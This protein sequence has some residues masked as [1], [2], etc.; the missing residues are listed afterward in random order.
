MDRLLDPVAQASWLD[1]PRARAY[2]LI[3]LV[4]A[5]GSLLFWIAGSR[6]GIDR[7]GH[8]L[9]TDFLAFWSAAR[10]AIAG[11][12]ADAWTLARIHAVERAAV[13]V[14]P[15]PSSFLYPPPFLLV[16]WPF[17]LLPYFTAWTVWVA[18]T[19]AAWLL[20]ARRWLGGARGWA[21]T[22]LAFPAAAIEA[23][24]GQNGF[25]TAALLGGGLWL[26]DRRPWLA[27][28]LLGAL[29]VKPQ[30]GLA[31]PVLVL[32]GGRWRVGLAGVASAAALSLA[33]LAAFGPGVWLA[34]RDGGALGR[35]I[36]E[37][38]LVEPE[39]MASA[40][41]AVRVL[42]GAP[43]LAY[44]CQAAVAAIAAACLA[45]VCRRRAAPGGVAA[46]TIVAGALMSPFLFDY[47]LV[48]TGFALAWLWREGL[49]RGFLQWE[50]AALAAA[51]ILPLVARTLALGGGIPIA[52]LVLLALLAA[53]VR[54][55]DHRHAAVDV[56]R[57]PGDVA[58][59][60]AGEIGDRGTDVL[61]P[62]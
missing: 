6:D 28:A 34:F 46:T 39:K 7:A 41:A 37:R 36:L 53:T 13:A 55:S 2:R 47:D 12:A 19:G 31:L 24:N 9:G 11:H 26:I 30:L 60:A 54:A 14:D 17:G 16:C 49:R 45:R 44:G 43:G 15:G 33:S 10:L 18:T 50:K 20:V 42:G 32:A 5:G 23:A 57:L 52:P 3:L 29:V 25:L 22:A 27:G 38:G 59:L 8:P 58:R 62:A 21:L 4:V 61:A 56:D 40:Y 51:F 1:G 48:G 35:A